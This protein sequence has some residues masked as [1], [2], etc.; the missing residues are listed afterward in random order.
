[1]SLKK[2]LAKLKSPRVLM[3]FLTLAV[4][5]L[6]LF[7]SRHGLVKAWD[8]LQQANLWLLALLIPFQ[9]VVYYAGGEMIFSRMPDG[10][11]H[12]L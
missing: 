7:L 4:L 1:M 12:L 2:I 8:L 11:H 6:I 9:M 3:S 5:A 10:A